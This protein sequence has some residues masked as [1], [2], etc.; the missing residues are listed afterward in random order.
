MADRRKETRREERPASGAFP[1]MDHREPDEPGE[2]E[3]TRTGESGSPE[4]R[5][6]HDADD[7]PLAEQMGQT[8]DRM[9]RGRKK[10]SVPPPA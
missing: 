9:L 10:G 5:I 7:P 4:L 1:W 8:M 6:T 2:T 3:L